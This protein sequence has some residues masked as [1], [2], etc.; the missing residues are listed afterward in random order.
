[1]QV[2][3]HLTSEDDMDQRSLEEGYVH[4][5]LW[6]QPK[7]LYL[8]FAVIFLHYLLALLLKFKFQISVTPLGGLSPAG[9]GF[10]SFLKD[11]L[12]SVSDR[13]CSSAL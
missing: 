3:R 8:Y 2:K 13:F 12:P 6:F 11:W 1:M 9:P 5:F 7:E 4:V 10:Q